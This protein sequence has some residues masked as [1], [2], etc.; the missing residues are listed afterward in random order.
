M[1]LRRDEDH[2]PEPDETDISEAI[3]ALGICSDSL[4]LEDRIQ[5]GSPSIFVSSEDGQFL[6]CD[7]R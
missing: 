2:I 7:I 5:Q 3:E 6:R 1:N 4:I